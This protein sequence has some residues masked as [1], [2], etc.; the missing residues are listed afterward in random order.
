MKAR[1]VVRKDTQ[2]CDV[3]E[4]LRCFVPGAIVAEPG[5]LTIEQC[6]MLLLADGEC[7]QGDGDVRPIRRGGELVGYLHITDAELIDTANPAAMAAFS[8]TG[9]GTRDE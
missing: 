6:L 7:A 5:T 9:A 3:G 8:R 2:G 1:R 4:P